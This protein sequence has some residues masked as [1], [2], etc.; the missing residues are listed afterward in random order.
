MITRVLAPNPSAM[1]LDGTATWVVQPSA[2]P[3]L[4]VDPGPEIESHRDAIL[5]ACP[6]GIAEIWLTHHHHD[7]AELAPELASVASAPVR[8]ADRDLC[9][10]ADPLTSGEQVTFGDLTVE[11]IALP[12]HTRDSLG[13]RIGPDLLV[14]DT[15][16][17]QGTTVIAHPDGHLGDYLASLDRVEALTDDGLERVLPA[18]GPEITDVPALVDA[19]RRH[20]HERLDQVRWALDAGAQSAEDVVAMVYDDVPDA[21]RFAA[22]MSVRAQLEYLGVAP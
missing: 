11:V 15:F 14:G 22:L 18:H 7:H 17:G 21:V 4:V 5:A 8:A 20:R 10:D 12:G 6:G 9:R 3:A 13:F 2:G 16:L 1:T 19:Y